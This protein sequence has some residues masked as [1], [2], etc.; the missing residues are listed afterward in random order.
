MMPQSF[1]GGIYYQDVQ[2]NQ[3]EL[4]VGGGYES[5]PTTFVRDNSMA[6]SNFAV[7]TSM[8]IVGRVAPSDGAT[9]TG[10]RFGLF[11]NVQ[12]NTDKVTVYVLC[13][14]AM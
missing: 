4:A 8:P 7:F 3:G 9:P 14:A 1:V 5:P 6:I 2:C 12:N 11:R 13:A 10:W